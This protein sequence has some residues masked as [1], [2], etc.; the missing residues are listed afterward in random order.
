MKKENINKIFE[1]NANKYDLMN[2]I[3]SFGLHRKWKRK[4]I[5]L[6]DLNLKNKNIILDLGCGT[7][8][9]ISQI[10][11]KSELN[12]NYLAYLVDPNILTQSSFSNS[13]LITQIKQIPHHP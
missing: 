13:I 11:N 8:D 1:S 5:D 12:S 2:D 10:N 4:F 9:I 6:I 7:G 3:M